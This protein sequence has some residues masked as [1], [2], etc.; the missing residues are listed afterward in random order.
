MNKENTSNRKPSKFDANIRVTHTYR[1]TTTATVTS[2]AIK[3]ADLIGVCGVMNITS[4]TA[5]R[6]IAYAVRVKWVKV[7]A[8]AIS[9]GSYI[10]GSCSVEWL[11]ENYHPSIDKSDST[12][13][14]SDPAYV[15]TSPPKGSDSGNWF[16]N[17]T[18][19]TLFNLSCTAGAVVDVCL[20]Y[21]LNDSTLVLTVTS[22]SNGTV[23][24]I[25]YRY[26]DASTS[27]SLVPVGLR[28][29]V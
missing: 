8:P 6:A 17:D 15:H 26:L 5:H 29:I 13:S 2:S 24:Q 10:S 7:W 19:A 20:E 25:Y 12:N 16:S 4:L 28:T 18:T 27:A 22:G 21:V 11:G 9:T 1:F 3:V 14:L 23:G